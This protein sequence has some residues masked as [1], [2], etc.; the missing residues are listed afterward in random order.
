[1][2]VPA[3]SSLPGRLVLTNRINRTA[4][5]FLTKTGQKCSDIRQG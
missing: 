4:L 3:L 1:M 2:Y 5:E